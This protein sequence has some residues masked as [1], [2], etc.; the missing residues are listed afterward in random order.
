MVKKRDN[1]IVKDALCKNHDSPEYTTPK[2]PSNHTILS[3]T[4]SC[5]WGLPLTLVG[6]VRWGTMVRGGSCMGAE[7][8]MPKLEWAAQTTSR[9]R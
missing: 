4:Q 6:I 2:I 9:Q 1:P 8:K 5:S 3:R 7:T